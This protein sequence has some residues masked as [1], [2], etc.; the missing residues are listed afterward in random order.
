MRLRDEVALVTGSTRGIGKAIAVMFAAEGARVVV[1]GR[2]RDLGQEVEKSIRD[3]GGEALY[4]P[5]DVG[6]EEDV[7]GA[8]GAAVDAFGKLTIL[9]NNAAP[10]ELVPVVDNAVA[11]LSS[12]HWESILRVTLT[13]AFWASK[14]SVREMIKAGGGSIVNISSDASTQGVAGLDSYT[15][16]K[17]G[18]N[19]LTRSIAVEYASRGI[20][21]NCFVVGFVPGDSPLANAIVN[22]PET[23][24]I[25]R[26]A[27]LTR[28]GRPEDVAYA[29][30]W[31]ASEEAA[32]V[33]GAII[34]ID[35]GM[36]AKSGLPDF[37][38]P[39]FVAAIEKAMQALAEPS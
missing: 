17:G 7:A 2:S 38:S 19:S 16:A 32:F 29:A 24:P 8:V 15:A 34:P 10:T 26:A 35:G 22:D 3:A 28:L 4:V 36:S 33:S 39:A 12:E 13:S 6:R 27:H 20:R 37:K 14:Y 1:T 18:M 23:G 30:V 31:L 11:D 5:T 25:C 9:V 21:C